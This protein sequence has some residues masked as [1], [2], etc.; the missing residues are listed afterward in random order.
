MTSLERLNDEL[1]RL[2]NLFNTKFYGGQLRKPVI[3]VQTNGGR[4]R[5]RLSMGWCTCDKIW[6]DHST[7]DYYYEIT[8][9]SE[10]L[11]RSVEEI[12]STLL[13]EM[14]HLYCNEQGIKD[15]SRGNTYHNKRFKELA[16]S[17]GLTVSY[18]ERIGWSCTRLSEA[19][20]SF[21]EENADK[22]VFVITRE[23]HSPPQAPITPTNAPE[24]E[25][26]ET[27]K[28]EPENGT[29]GTTEPPKTKQSLRKYVCPK[30]GCI[31]RASREVN[32]ICGECKVP[33]EQET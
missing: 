4:G 1:N 21:V 33:F 11:Y 13:H 18:D 6:K 2:F 29:Q 30:C 31:I 10:Y 15:T 7:N 25:G 3:A 16:E 24:G 23:R 5:Q 28:G 14:V 20:A 32:V 19:A 22:S 26:G 17:H 12:C 8:I 9:C 27:D